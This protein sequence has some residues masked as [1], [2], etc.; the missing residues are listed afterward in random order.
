MRVEPT[1]R[2]VDECRTQ[3][4]STNATL[5]QTSWEPVDPDAGRCGLS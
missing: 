4:S 3:H 1:F 5:E 2:L